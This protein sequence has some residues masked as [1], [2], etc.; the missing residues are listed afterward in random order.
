MNMKDSVLRAELAG[1]LN[2]GQAH[3]DLNKALHGLKPENRTKIG[4]PGERSIWEVLEHIRIA[5]HDILSYTLDPDW[6]S[7]EWPS[8]YWPA[9]PARL[10]EKAWAKTVDGLRGDLNEMIKLVRNG[11]VDLTAEIPHSEG[12]TYLREVLLAADHNAYHLGQVVAMRK[13]LGDWPD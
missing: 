11:E 6:R 9:V 3:V 5:Q 13:S 2:V 7:P 12:H 10:T 4:I 1:L 8:G